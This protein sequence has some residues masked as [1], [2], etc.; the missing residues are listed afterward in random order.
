M[1]KYL[2]RNTR[3]NEDLN[4]VMAS[5]NQTSIDIRDQLPT[6][7][8]KAH[9]PHI[10][11]RKGDLPILYKLKFRT[12]DYTKTSVT[13]TN[14]QKAIP[15][16][17][18]KHITRISIGLNNVNT[19]KP[20]PQIPLFKRKFSQNTNQAAKPLKKQTN[21]HNWVSRNRDYTIYYSKNIKSAIGR[22]KQA[23][24]KKII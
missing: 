11:I 16:K 15:Q 23:I 5:S 8:K 4:P 14:E 7:T 19:L 6:I 1:R 13:P 24:H 12:Y 10:Q 2:R 22:L 9:K 20:N 3:I 21:I 17:E 18:I